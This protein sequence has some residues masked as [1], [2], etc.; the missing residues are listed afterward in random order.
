[1]WNL[2][3][4]H[5]SINHVPV[6]LLPAALVLFAVAS[7]RRS[8]LL[9]RAGIVVAWVAALFALASYFTGDAAAD[10][11][12][13]VETAQKKI[14]DP[15]V[16]EHDDAAGWALGCSL[17]LAAAGIWGWRRKGLGREVT[18]PLLIVSVLGTAILFRTAQLG[19]RIRHPE[20]RPGFVAPVEQHGK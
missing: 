3:H 12:M 8:E 2:A 10:L 6:V 4:L 20:A 19:G 5:I 14:L 11:V 17:L 1:M 15:L 9:L 7:W 16:G 13:A 18:L